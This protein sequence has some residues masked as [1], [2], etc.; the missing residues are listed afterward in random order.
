MWV[1][2]GYESMSTM[3]GELKDPQVIPKATLISIPLITFNLQ[4]PR[5]VGTQDDF[6]VGGA[7]D[8]IGH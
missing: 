7:D 1:Y 5:V 2:S 3:A 4:D 6:L 8:G